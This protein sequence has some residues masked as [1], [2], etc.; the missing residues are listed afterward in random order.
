[1]I[2]ATGISPVSAILAII[3]LAI[4]SKLVEILVDNVLEFLSI[5]KDKSYFPYILVL[6]IALAWGIYGLQNPEP[7]DAEGGMTFVASVT[8]PSTKIPSPTPQPRPTPTPQPTTARLEPVF[9]NF[10][11]CDENCA[12]LS[13]RI[14]SRYTGPT[15]DI[16]LSVDYLNIP[17]AAQYTREWSNSGDKWIKISCTWKGPGDGTLQINL[18]DREVGLRKGTWEMTL[19][20]SVD[21]KKYSFSTTI[22][23][24]DTNTR[25]DP[26][27]NSADCP[28]W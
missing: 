15:K 10:R 4:L 5:P 14:V 21:G 9:E 2:E 22:F 23:I 24:D 26:V 11:F 13:S 16:W 25:W 1:M 12:L 6:T 20:L 28:D 8:P 17:Y 18:Y 27:G 7:T 19:T 3:G